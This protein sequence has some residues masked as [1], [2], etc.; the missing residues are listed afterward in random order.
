M[1]NRNR[2]IASWMASVVVGTYAG[3]WGY[4]TLSALLRG[5]MVRWA[6]LMAVASAVAAFQ[7]MILGAID[8]VLLWA[9]ARMLPQGRR[10][11]LGSIGS[12][13]V[14]LSF[15]LGWPLTR[16]LSPAGLFFSLLPMIAVPLAVRMIWGERC[17]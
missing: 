11:W 10:A 2:S 9:K 5:G 17:D 4:A 7:V 12:S 16:W 3:A 8:I 6:L 1:M 13:A 14:G 15:T